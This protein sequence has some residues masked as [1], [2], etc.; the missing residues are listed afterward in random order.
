M[1]PFRFARLAELFIA[2][3][4]LTGDER[5]AYLIH[6]CADDE[7]L[8]VEI[9]DLLVRDAE[10]AGRLDRPAGLRK[11]AE[12]A[13]DASL[14]AASAA[15]PEPTR[16]GHYRVVKRI[17]S[18]GMGTVYEAFDE[19]LERTVAVKVLRH[20]VTS[21]ES[22]RQFEI[23]ARALARL[24]HPGIARI[25]ASGSALV[26]GV[27][28]SWIAMERVDGLPLLEYVRT[29]GLGVAPR[30][31]LV[32]GIAHAVAHA[33]LHGVI[34]RDLKPAN[35]LV[36]AS[37]QPKV[38]DFGVA[39]IRDD[40]GT[41]TA[42]NTLEGRIIGTLAYMSPEQALGDAEHVDARTDVYSLGVLAYE[43]LTGRLPV[44]VDRLPLAAAARAIVEQEPA[45]LGSVDPTLEGDLSA[46]VAKAMAKDVERRYQG[47][48]AFAEDVRRWLD[49]EPVVARAPTVVEHVR[50]FVRRNAVLVSATLAVTAALV[51]GVVLALGSAKREQTARVRA[52]ASA[53]RAE[54]AAA[55]AA[56]RLGDPADARAH[57]ERA[58]SAHRGWEWRYLDA[59]L[60]TSVARVPISVSSER[61]LAISPDLRT[62]A[63]GGT[64][65]PVVLVDTSDGKPRGGP[66][67]FPGGALRGAWES[68]VLVLGGP[69]GAIT[70]FDGRNPGATSTTYDVGGTVEALALTRDARRLVVAVNGPD[71]VRKRFRLFVKDLS[72]GFDLVERVGDDASGSSVAFSD[73]G[74]SIALGGWNHRVQLWRAGD[75]A[76]ERSLAGHSNSVS[77]LAFLGDDRLVSGGHDRSVIVW[78]TKTG[79]AGVARRGHAAVV[80]A[81]SPA[82]GGRHIASAARDGTVRVWDAEPGTPATVLEV[83]APGEPAV[84]RY[85]ADGAW[86]LAA[87]PSELRRWPVAGRRPP[88][89]LAGHRGV[90]E[91]N[92]LPYVYDVDWSPDGAHLLSSGWDGT[93]RIWDAATGRLERTLE[94]DALVRSGGWAPDGRSVAAAC[95]D[96]TV[97]G[98][99]AAD[100]S[101]RGVRKGLREA[102]AG[103]LAYTPSGGALLVSGRG[104]DLESLDPT[105]HATVAT[106]RGHEAAVFSAAYSADGALCATGDA[107]GVCLLRDGATGDVKARLADDL[108]AVHGVAFSPDATQIALAGKDRTV[109]VVDVRSRRVLHSLKGHADAVYCVAWTPDG[110]RIASGSSDGTIRLFDASSGAELLVLTGHTA[111]VMA[112]AF[113]PDGATLASASGDNTVRLW[114]STP[115]AERWRR[116]GLPSPAR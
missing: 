104:F 101:A 17:G 36:E 81:I 8:R 111:Y 112:V 105:T 77:A 95:G 54:I 2:A 91:G 113:S 41:A 12:A 22:R 67:P 66:I 97:H 37:G 61:P 32:M 69:S 34:H 24:T 75:L 99:D 74:R 82:P 35:V 3:R 108:L 18:G 70:V 23:E 89:R 94:C 72:T 57:L 56:L 68:D 58:P 115:F 53:Y 73:D 9:D 16:I 50:R 59:Q 103:A 20:D 42:R 109:R 7:S 87:T 60:D 31:R 40:A 19:A 43:L 51:T 15:P 64:D 10:L 5:V 100:G 44:D 92:Q 47:A 21:K 63:L 116:A 86:L 106:W 39:R 83:G 76:P 25:L 46:I 78:N 14:T 49:D 110:T 80:D 26:S 33:H 52:E 93:L 102:G 88:E 62:V 85:A 98:F 6:E 30:M 1:T 13:L 107:A 96:G 29:A 114:S 84:A 38:L 71:V 28:R 65:R 27:V 90:A 48:A 4:R 79:E 45:T 11:V 55:A